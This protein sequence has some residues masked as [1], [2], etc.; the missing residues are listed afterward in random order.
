MKKQEN[1]YR[2]RKKL[3][4]YVVEKQVGDK[5]EGKTLIPEKLWNLLVS[6]KMSEEMSNSTQEAK[7]EPPQRFA[8]SSLNALSK[9]DTKQDLVELTPED[10]KRMHEKLK[11]QEPFEVPEEDENE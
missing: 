7:P 11:D 9:K 6:S 1:N 5:W 10:I 4:K 8:Q 2:I 3:D